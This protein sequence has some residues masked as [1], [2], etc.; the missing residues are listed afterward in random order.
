MLGG[1]HA[2]EWVPPD[3]LVS[4]AAD[5][6]EAH[7]GGTGL[8]YGG[9]SYSAAEIHRIVETLNIFFFACV[10]PDGRAHSQTVAS[11]WRK[12][13]RPAPT[14]MTGADCVGVDLNRNFDF[15]WDHTARF[16]ADSGVSASSSPCHP[17]LYRGPSA[18]SEPET[19]NVVAILDRFPR[20]RWHVDVHSAVP[21][22]LHSWGDDENQS[23]APGDSFLNPALDTVRGR[24]GDGVG[25]FVSAADVA[26]ITEL[27]QRIGAGVQDAHGAV[28]DVEQAMTL[29]PTSGASDDYAYSRHFAN[30][31][32]NRVYAWTIEC[33]TSFQPA[34]P[35]AVEVIG[36]VSSGLVRLALGAHAV[37]DGLAVSLR[38]PAVAFVDVPEG[39]R[40]RA[41]S[42]G[43]A[44][45]PSTCT[46]R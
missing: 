15:L 12:N 40:P 14:G 6:L 35:T 43:T 34:W 23:G 18:A 10:N 22:V 8:G 25:E 41:P 31:V 39:R 36:E 21:V 1:V 24:L 46:S 42:A 26:I 20:I 37:T 32:L 17:T 45:G 44:A 3:A 27:A 28:Y 4:L 11:G 2:R 38:T 29:Y 9:A 16:A 33:G 5:L 7:A 19:R 30:P 13:R